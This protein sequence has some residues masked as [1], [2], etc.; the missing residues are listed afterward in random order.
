MNLNELVSVRTQLMN[1]LNTID[2]EI[3]EYDWQHLAN[4]DLKILAIRA[5]RKNY[6][7]SIME[8]KEK[9]EAFIDLIKKPY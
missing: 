7:C 9:V 8:A 3:L 5:Y 1:A 6:D 2:N 4:R